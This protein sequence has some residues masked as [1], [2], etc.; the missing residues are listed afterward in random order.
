VRYPD[1]SPANDALVFERGEL[2]GNIWVMPLAGSNDAT[3]TEAPK[4]ARSVMK[5][6]Q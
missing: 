3:A 2:R 1:W 5:S 6:A 4:Q